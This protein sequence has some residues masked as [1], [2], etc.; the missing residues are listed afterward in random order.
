[1]KYTKSL[2]AMLMVGMSFT[3]C[4]EFEDFDAEANKVNHPATFE[5]GH[6]AVENASDAANAYT[7]IV[8]KCTEMVED[9]TTNELVAKNDTVIYVLTTNKENGSVRTVGVCHNAYYDVNTGMLTGVCEVSHYEDR[10]VAALAYDRF[11]NITAQVHHGASADDTQT[12]VYGKATKSDEMPT[13]YGTWYAGEDFAIYLTP[14]DVQY[15][16]NGEVI[17]DAQGNPVL[18]YGMFQY[19]QTADYISAVTVENNV[20]TVK[21][22]N[23]GKVITLKYN[24]EMQMEITVD[25]KAL[26]CDRAV[27]EPEPET[28]TEVATG[29]Y[30][31][32]VSASVQSNA[33]A[34]TIPAFLPNYAM[35][36]SYE[37]TLYQGERNKNRYLIYPWFSE[38][39]AGLEFEVTDTELAE[40]V[41]LISVPGSGTGI[42]DTSGELYVCDQYYAFGGKIENFDSNFNFE[43]NTVEFYHILCTPS[44]YYGID[45]DQFLI[46]G[47]AGTQKKTFTRGEKK[48]T[49]ARLNQILSSNM[50]IKARK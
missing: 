16:D 22:L 18:M 25:D 44:S 36:K 24:A 42:G 34:Q 32:A 49:R 31:H 11:G 41:Y 10:L 28:Y 4:N 40:N 50:S 37:S 33:F 23:T 2:L 27:S 17:V 39:T 15:D 13:V 7:F 35:D 46:T 43:T 45:H 48:N 20:A 3:A 9:T 14:G 47:E 8:G 19:G 38:K 5:Y 6:Y 12:I 26:V 30:V 21:G 29:I 1:M